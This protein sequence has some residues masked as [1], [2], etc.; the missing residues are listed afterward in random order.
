MCLPWGR[1]V[2]LWSPRFGRGCCGPTASA[3][4][5][6]GP[7]GRT[8]VPAPRWALR[9][10]GRLP[11]PL[12][13]QTVKHV[14]RPRF[15]WFWERPR[16]RVGRQSAVLWSGVGSVDVLGHRVTLVLPPPTSPSRS[17]HRR[18]WTSAAPPCLPLCG[19]LLG[20]WRV[21]RL[22]ARVHTQER[23]QIFPDLGLVAG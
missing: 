16:S 10:L 7:R 8:A 23:M 14:R 22:V 3:P 11:P 13:A 2:W 17:H 6:Q 19:H 4:C 15:C 21:G 5:V 1:T 12:E 20:G 9:V 18:P